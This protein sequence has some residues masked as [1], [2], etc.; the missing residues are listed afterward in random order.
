M[1]CVLVGYVRKQ[2][3]QTRRGE[4]DG[5][6]LAEERTEKWGESES[7]NYRKQSSIRERGKGIG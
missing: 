1:K 5:E 2:Q 3:Q 6:G 7:E 4:K